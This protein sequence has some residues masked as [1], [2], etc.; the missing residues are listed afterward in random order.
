MPR[1]KSKA[2]GKKK[3]GTKKCAP[4]RQSVKRMNTA[5]KASKPGGA[6]GKY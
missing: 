3:C 5:K 1:K 6:R 4:K 2:S